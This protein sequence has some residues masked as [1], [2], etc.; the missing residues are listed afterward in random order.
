MQLKRCNSWGGGKRLCLI[1]T[2]IDQD[3]HLLDRRGQLSDPTPVVAHISL[4]PG[5]EIEAERVRSKFDRREGIRL[6]RQTADFDSQHLRR[7][8]K[9]QCR[10]A[11]VRGGH[12]IYQFHYPVLPALADRL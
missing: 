7:G 2:R 3:R 11:E 10:F 5:K 1:P 12:L 4:A 9:A 6:R 8:G